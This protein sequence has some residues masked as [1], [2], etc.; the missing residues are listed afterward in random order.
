M[1]L[2]PIVAGLSV[3][4]AACDSDEGKPTGTSSGTTTTPTPSTDGGSDGAKKKLAEDCT[5][6]DG[7]ECESG[8]CFVDRQS[9]CTVRCSGA[10]AGEVCVPPLTTQCNGKGYCKRN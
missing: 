2:A 6:A 8:V 5:N 7:S 10:N 9:F 1:R 3:L 4:I